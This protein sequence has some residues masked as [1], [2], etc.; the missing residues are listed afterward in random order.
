MTMKSCELKLQ[1]GQWKELPNCIKTYEKIG[2]KFLS[3][4]I[5][6]TSAKDLF[7]ISNL[8]FMANEDVIGAK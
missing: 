4:P 6:K 8:C 5:L 3:T 1:A 2:K 7:F